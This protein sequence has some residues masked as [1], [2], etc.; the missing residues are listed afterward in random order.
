MPA[1]LL[2]NIW[3]G[4]NWEWLPFGD[5]YFGSRLRIGMPARYAYVGAG[6]GR[7]P[8]SKGEIG[9]VSNWDRLGTGCEV[10]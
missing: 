4:L 10:E 5:C 7:N 3:L 9:A 1:V 6:F 8:K 2:D